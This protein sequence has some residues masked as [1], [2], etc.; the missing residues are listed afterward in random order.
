MFTESQFPPVLDGPCRVVRSPSFCRAFDR[1]R[2][3]AIGCVTVADACRGRCKAQARGES[4]LDG[5]RACMHAFAVQCLG[6]LRSV[7]KA[8]SVAMCCAVLCCAVLCR[9][10]PK[11][12]R[13]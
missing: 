8:R 5:M 11:A 6:L 13:T 4:Q 1:A 7:C 2:A 3:F 12:D 9:L 10:S